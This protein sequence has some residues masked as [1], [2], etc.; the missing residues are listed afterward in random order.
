[1]IEIGYKLMAETF[2]PPEIV[3]E[4]QAAATKASLSEG[5]FTL[6]IGAGE[7][8]NEH[9][10]GAGWPSVSVRHEMVRESVEII[11]PP[12]PTDRPACPS[13]RCNRRPTPEGMHR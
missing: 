1:M 2:A 13:R 3:R 10:V 9:V 4:A 5:R 12:T 7:N 6:G 8:L 11:R